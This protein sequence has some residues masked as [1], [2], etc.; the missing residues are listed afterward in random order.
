ML[1]LSGTLPE[2]ELG[3]ESEMLQEQV[4]GKNWVGQNL[5]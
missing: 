2:A 4:G 5:D 1:S 3:E